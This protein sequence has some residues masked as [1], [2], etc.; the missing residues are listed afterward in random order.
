MFYDDEE[1]LA[2][3]YSLIGSQVKT[4]IVLTIKS[5]LQLNITAQL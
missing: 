1:F 2:K 4:I 3:Q 5:L